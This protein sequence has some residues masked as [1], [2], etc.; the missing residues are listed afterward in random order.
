MTLGA[1]STGPC[2]VSFDL[3]DRLYNSFD[4][5]QAHFLAIATN[6]QHPS[7]F[8]RMPHNTE[9]GLT[10]HRP[11]SSVLVEMYSFGTVLL[12]SGLDSKTAV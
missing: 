5:H 10:S 7:F 1:V 9:A 6:L 12:S 11:S 8:R 4:T 3:G 2:C